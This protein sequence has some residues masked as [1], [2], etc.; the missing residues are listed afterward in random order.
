MIYIH[1]DHCPSNICVEDH[2]PK[3]YWFP[4]EAI[5]TKKPFTPQQ[6]KQKR[7]AKLALLDEKLKNTCF[8]WNMLSRIKIVRKGILGKN[9]NRDAFN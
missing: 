1:K 6:R 5:C 9:P 3:Y 7:I 8:N 4:N 2:N